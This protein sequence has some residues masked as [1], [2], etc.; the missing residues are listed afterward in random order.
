MSGKTRCARARTRLAGFALAWSLAG[1]GAAALASEARPE[2][3]APAPCAVMDKFDGE[4]QVL[5]ATRTHLVDTALKTA[6]PCGGWVSVR[7]GT[8]EIRHRQ[9]YSFKLGPNSFVEFY[10]NRGGQQLTG[11]DQ[12]VLYRGSL[13]VDAPQ[14][15]EP[16]SVVTANARARLT[17]GTAV[18]IYSPDDEETQL[19]SLAHQ[20]S[21]HNRFVGTGAVT[22]KEGEATSLNMKLKRAVPETPAVVSMA[23]LR[24]VLKE[25]PIEAREA[26]SA[27]ARVRKRIERLFAESGRE[28]GRNPASARGP[29][30]RHPASAGGTPQWRGVGAGGD[31]S[32]L[33][34][35][36]RKAQARKADV[37]LED[38]AVIYER[39][40]R[41]E[42]DQEKDRLIRALSG[43][44]SGH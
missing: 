26:A 14:G 9:G 11:D 17:H 42:Q 28:K 31:A 30:D 32:I 21:L 40:K 35:E 12:V 44:K 24:R 41:Q 27:T 22:V 20:A 19:L 13:W 16:V 38:P 5:D 4:V 15:N 39:R 2:A 25:L 29:Y 37:L 3:S 8:A 18:V 23:S 43:I 6:I 33:F 10:D 7:D 1:S 34:P 36:G